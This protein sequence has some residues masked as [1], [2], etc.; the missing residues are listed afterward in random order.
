MII[1]S[2]FLS[3]MCF[4]THEEHLSSS[5]SERIHPRSVVIPR[6][7][8]ECVRGREGKGVETSRESRVHDEERVKEREPGEGVEGWW[9]LMKRFQSR[10]GFRPGQSIELLSASRHEIVDRSSGSGSR[11]AAS[12]NRHV[13]DP[14]GSCIRSSFRIAPRFDHSNGEER[15]SWRISGRLDWG[16][17]VTTF[18]CTQP[19]VLLGVRLLFVGYN[20]V[21]RC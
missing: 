13:I 21:V 10:D 16:G 14:R 2:L 7:D 8:S 5:S 19:P 12:D 17:W 3:L 15:N 20:C 1:S 6:S 18:R 11:L 4:K 9:R